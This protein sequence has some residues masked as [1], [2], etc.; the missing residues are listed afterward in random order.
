MQRQADQHALG[1]VADARHEQRPAGQA[2]IG[3]HLRHMLVFEAEAIQEE[4]RGAAGGL[5]FRDH[6]LAAAAVA[7]DGVD[8]DGIV[9][10]QDAPLDQRADQRDGAGRV[11]AG[12]GNAWRRRDGRFLRGR[13]LGEAIDPVRVGAMGGGGIEQLRRIGAEGRRHR[14]RVL[15]GVVGQAEHDEIDFRHQGAL[16]VRVL[17]QFG[18]DGTQR[19]AGEAR[20]A[21]TDLQAGGAGLAIDEDAG[22]G[23][24]GHAAIPLR[25]K[26]GRLGARKA[27][28]AGPCGPA[29]LMNQPCGRAVTPDPPGVS[30][31]RTGRNVG[32]SPCRTSCAPPRA[33]RASG[34]RP[35]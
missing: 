3:L 11:A 14:G 8:R 35:S 25:R 23:S 22:D 17:A 31:W 7:G 2:A 21:V 28:G 20:Q 1:E 32:P 29:P 19:D 26:K 24:L 16:G 6:R 4:G 34:S 33:H 13:Q 27:R 15:R 5:E 30:A 9:L 12:V 10:R 18:R